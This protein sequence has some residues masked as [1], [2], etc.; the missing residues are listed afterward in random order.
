MLVYH[1]VLVLGWINLWSARA[2]SFKTYIELLIVTVLGL[3]RKTALEQGSES[4]QFC[5][6]LDL[7]YVVNR[8]V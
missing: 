1:G 5:M 4:R 8:I 2:T 7:F 6:G 3:T